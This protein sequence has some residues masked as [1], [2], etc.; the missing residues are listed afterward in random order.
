[1][2]L[3]RL[4]RGQQCE[5]PEHTFSSLAP[6]LRCRIHPAGIIQHQLLD[7]VRLA[8]SDPCGLQQMSSRNSAT[9][10]VVRTTA[11]IATARRTPQVGP[12]RTGYRSGF[13]ECSGVSCTDMNMRQLGA[14][15]A[16]V[17]CSLVRCSIVTRLFLSKALKRPRSRVVFGEPGVCLTGGGGLLLLLLMPGGMVHQT[18]GRDRLRE[19]VMT[20]RRDAPSL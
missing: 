2:P 19:S 18:V 4:I 9:I 15:S 5:S 7:D 11:A 3:I 12:Q 13:P 14:W 20:C 16:V 6:T 1:M 8:S 17:S 10:E